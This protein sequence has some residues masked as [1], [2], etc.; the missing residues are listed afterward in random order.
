MAGELLFGRFGDG[1]VEFHVIIIKEFLAGLDVAQCVNEDSVVFLDRFAVWIAGMIDPARV[2][3]ANFRIDYFAV[4]QSEVE[5]VRIVVV[6][7]AAS[8]ETRSPV[9]SI[10]RVPSGMKCPA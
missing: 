10:M 6:V 4:F 1:F 5:S 8:Q 2:V 7:G 9:Y 3:T